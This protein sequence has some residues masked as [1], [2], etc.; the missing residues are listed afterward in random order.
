M[1]S[2]VASAGLPTR[3]HSQKIA[4]RWMLYLGKHPPPPSPSCLSE[5]TRIPSPRRQQPIYQGPD[6]LYRA[7]P[8]RDRAS[9]W[10]SSS[11]AAFRSRLKRDGSNAMADRGPDRSCRRP[12]I[13]G[14]SATLG[15]RRDPRFS[16]ETI[17]AVWDGNPPKQ[18]HLIAICKA[19]LRQVLA[20]GRTCGMDATRRP[21]A[22]RPG[23][24]GGQRSLAQQQLPARG[25][26][27]AFLQERIPGSRG[28]CSSVHTST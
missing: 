23:R 26:P 18:I 12:E 5:K 11:T 9:R 10:Q 25:R 7:P 1:P 6:A 16:Q 2:S 14:R 22:N 13:L 27:S 24:A 4:I 21:E 28:G 17:L 8:D 20:E 3:A 19:G 15:E